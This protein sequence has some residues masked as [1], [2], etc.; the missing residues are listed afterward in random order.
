[1]D[2][3]LSIAVNPNIIGNI[4]TM[5]REFHVK[6]QVS[7]PETP[8]SPTSDWATQVLADHQDDPTYNQLKAIIDDLE[9][10]Q[11]VC[12]VAVMWLG[13]GDFTIEEWDNALQHAGDSWNENTAN[14][15]LGHPLLS[16]YLEEGLSLLGYYSE[17][18]E[19]Q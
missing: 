5:A 11:Q 7:I 6:E 15:L 4:I 8:L 13:R 9:P 19:T 1:M 14:Y 10:D 16:N 17:D 18:Y 12:I 2:K 3:K